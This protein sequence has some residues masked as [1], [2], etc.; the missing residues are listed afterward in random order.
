MLCIRSA[1]V[2]CCFRSACLSFSYD[3]FRVRVLRFRFPRLVC[4]VRVLIFVVDFTMIFV[5]RLYFLCVVGACAF[6]FFVVCLGWEFQAGRPKQ[7]WRA[8]EFSVNS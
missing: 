8:E 5:L 6:F 3:W 1:C 2:L 4:C 7:G